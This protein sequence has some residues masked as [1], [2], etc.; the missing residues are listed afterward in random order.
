MKVLRLHG[1]HDLRLHDESM[2]TPAQGEALIKVTSVGV[3]GSD[4]HWFAEQGIGDAHLDVPLV[5][6][7]E[8][9]GKLQNGERVAVDPAISCGHCEPC[10]HGHPN[11]CLSIIFAGYGTQDGSLREYMAWNERNLFRIPDSITDDDGAMLEPL[12]VAIHAVDLAHLK[13]GMTVGVFGCGPIGLLIIQMAKLA[14]A[15]NIIATDKLAHRVEAAKAFGADYAFLVGDNS[16]LGQIRAATN[17]RGV[18]VAF[19]AAGVQETVDVSVAAVLHGGK[20][21]LVGIPEEEN[22]YFSA[23][24]SRRKGLTM[25]FVRRMKHTYPRAIELVSKGLVDVRSLVTHRFPFE[26][27]SEAFQLAERREGLKVVVEC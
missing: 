4:L 24:A 8:F 7:H 11:L 10:Q 23:S 19:E 25:I 26:K 18:D 12:G 3:C 5:L 14:G 13:A 1:P 21:M 20:V 27:A 16:E 9:A 15:S 17:G 22:I 2:P 6:G